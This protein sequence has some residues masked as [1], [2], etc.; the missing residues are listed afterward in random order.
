MTLDVGKVGHELIRAFHLADGARVVLGEEAAE[1]RVPGL[2][3]L[4][5]CRE[6]HRGAL[7]ELADGVRPG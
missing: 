4:A 7:D 3:E 6:L 1:R 5:A 2:V